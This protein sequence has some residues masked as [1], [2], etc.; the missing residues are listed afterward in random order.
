MGRLKEWNRNPE[1]RL[2]FLPVGGCR[3]RHKRA[4]TE[5]GLEAL[6]AAGLVQKSQT[7]GGPFKFE[8]L[9]I[10]LNELVGAI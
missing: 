6:E 10:G 8:R 7:S 4:A 9:V 1:L 3:R 2:C 5:V